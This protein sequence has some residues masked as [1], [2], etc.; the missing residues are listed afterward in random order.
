MDKKPHRAS[1]KPGSKNSRG[2]KN[3]GF[4]ALIV[5]FGLIVFAASNQPSTLKEISSTQAIADTNAG[6]YSKIV[7]NNNQLEITPKGKEQA[8][9]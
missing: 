6:K 1:R 5:L 2:A 3:I 8:N 9:T 7:V 4:I